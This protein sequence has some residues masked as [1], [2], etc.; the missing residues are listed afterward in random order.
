MPLTD[1]MLFMIYTHTTLSVHTHTLCYTHLLSKHSGAM[2]AGVPADLVSCTSLSMV[3]N[4]SDTPKSAIYIK[5][6]LVM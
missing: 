3:L 5:M 4:V 1:N 6:K 2:N